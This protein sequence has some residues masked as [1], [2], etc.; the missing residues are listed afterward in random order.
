VVDDGYQDRA[1]ELLDGHKPAGPLRGGKYS[2]FEGG[3]RIPFILR[4]PARVKPGVSEALVCHVDFLASFAALTG[5]SLAPT[6]APDSFNVLAA[7]LGA[8]K[9][10][11]ED[12]VEHAGAL[13]LRHGPQKYIEPGRG[14]RRNVE[15]NTET[16]Q[17][18]QG[19]FYQLSNDLGETNNLAAQNPET[20]QELTTLLRQARERGRT[21]P[22][23][24]L[25]EGQ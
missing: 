7:L 12:L 23:Q 18:P 6:D 1:V 11:R 5:Q 24:V 15:T 9:L 14:P 17:A 2:I 3:T 16:G 20:V 22:S 19:Q 8:S 13:A 25:R 4:W 21:R 10:G